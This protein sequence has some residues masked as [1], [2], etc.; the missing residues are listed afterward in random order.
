MIVCL[1]TCLCAFRS[2]AHAPSPQ[3]FC[4]TPCDD[5]SD[6]G[7]VITVL[8]EVARRRGRRRDVCVNVSVSV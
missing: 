8:C 1:S 6:L 7:R 4:V 2:I 5:E 3:S